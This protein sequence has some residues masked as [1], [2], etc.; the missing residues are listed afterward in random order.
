[1]KFR[2]GRVIEAGLASALPMMPF[3]FCETASA[4]RPLERYIQ[5][6]VVLV[7]LESS[8]D[9]QR[10]VFIHPPAHRWQCRGGLAA[11]NAPRNSTRKQ[12]HGKRRIAEPGRQ[13]SEAAL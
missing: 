13:V 2:D 6:P 5:R 9:N 3:H 10:K 11:S 12:A 1:M 8:D 4:A 7:D